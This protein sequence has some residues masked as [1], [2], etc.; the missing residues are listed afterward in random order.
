MVLELEDMSQEAEEIFGPPKH[1][2]KGNDGSEKVTNA[3]DSRP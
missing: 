1:D 2:G 3:Q